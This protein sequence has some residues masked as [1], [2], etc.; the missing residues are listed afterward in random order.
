VTDAISGAGMEPGIYKLDGQDILVDDTFARLPDG[1][2]AGSVLTL[3]QA[4]RNVVEWTGVGVGDACRMASEV[5]ARLLGLASTGKIAVGRD[6]DL[7][8][9]NEALQVTATFR[10]GRCLYQRSE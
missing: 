1:K 9:L 7:V 4:V 2:L 6:A 10:Q 5:P 3:D 8:L